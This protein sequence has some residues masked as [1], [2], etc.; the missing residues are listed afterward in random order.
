VFNCGVV[1]IFCRNVGKQRVYVCV[2]ILVGV[3][4]V[5]CCHVVFYSVG[6]LVYATLCVC[7]YWS[8][9]LFM[10]WSF[11]CCRGIF[12]KR[13]CSAPYA[14]DNPSLVCCLSFIFFLLVLFLSVQC[15]YFV[16]WFKIIR[17]AISH[18]HSAYRFLLRMFISYQF[19][20]MLFISVNSVYRSQ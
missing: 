20:C 9:C 19:V 18:Y 8:A 14:Y 4:V 11:F 13:Q 15:V 7:C 12:P 3:Y 2:F 10:F 1:Y 16:V 6:R 5:L 17:Y